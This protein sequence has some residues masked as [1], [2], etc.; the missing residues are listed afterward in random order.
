MRAPTWYQLV[1][2][3]ALEETPTGP[4][5]GCLNRTQPGSPSSGNGVGLVRG[6]QGLPLLLLT[7]AV[8]VFCSF[9]F[10]FRAS[11]A[12]GGVNGTQTLSWSTAFSHV[13]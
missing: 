5:L 3:A 2:L 8:F 13:R 11:C 1:G 12:L 10:P 6:A 7:R 4:G 9:V